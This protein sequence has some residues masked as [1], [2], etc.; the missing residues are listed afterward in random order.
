MQSEL[1]VIALEP[2][3][4]AVL[5]QSL[6]GGQ[7]SSLEPGV[8]DFLVQAVSQASLSQEAAGTAAA[9]LVPDRIRLALARLLRKAAPRL[10]STR[11]SRDSRKQV[12]SHCQSHWSR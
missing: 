1:E 9:L 7:T 10:T 5:M 3:L 2:G 6:G 4:E 8:A 11:A 12:D